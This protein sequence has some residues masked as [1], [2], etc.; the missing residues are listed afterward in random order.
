MEKVYI[1]D[2]KGNMRQAVKDLFNQV[3]EEK[4][5]LL[6]KSKKVFLKVNGIDFKKHCHTS[7]EFLEAVILHLKD[8]GA[9]IFVMEN[10]TQSN[11]TRIVFEVIGYRKICKKHGVKIIYLDEEHTKTI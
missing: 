9:E 10:S 11:M 8:L 2:I 1:Q 5:P 3:G 6:K 4:V 7:P